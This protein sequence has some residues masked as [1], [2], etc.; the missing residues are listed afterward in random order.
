MHRRLLFAALM[1]WCVALLALRVVRTG[2][3]MYAFLAWNLFLAI[4]PLVASERLVLAKRRFAQ[5]SC[6]ALWLLFLP[7]APYILTDLI[8]LRPRPPV[9]LWFDLAL[10]LS[11]AGT[12]LLLGY[13]SV[14][15]VH[16]FV[17]RRFGAVAGWCIAVASLLLSAF[18]MYLGRFLRWNSWDVLGNP[19]ALLADVA[20]RVV[21]PLAHPRTVGVTMIF[22]GMLVLGYLAMN[23]LPH[24]DETLGE[25]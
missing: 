17:A 2:S 24:R 16:G 5:A 23:T 11:C 15:N 21:N 25:R 9:P 1:S 18:G 8:H 20:R 3:L 13:A 22:G 19:M 12:G 14:A 4:V 7:N 10:L 6:L